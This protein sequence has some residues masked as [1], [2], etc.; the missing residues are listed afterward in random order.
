MRTLPLRVPVIPGESLDSWLEALAR[1]NGLT[2]SGL[3]PSLGWQ[4]PHVFSRLVVNVPVPILRGI[5]HR[6]GLP[7]GRL[8]DAVLD[9][10]LPALPVRRTG[11]RYCPSCLAAN[12]GRWLLAWHLPWVFTCT[13]HRILLCDTCPGCGHVPRVL[14]GVAGV[15]P[16]GSCP[17]T[18]AGSASR[19]C[20][21]DLRADPRRHAPR[22]QMLA[23]QHWINTILGIDGTAT[24]VSAQQLSDLE[25]VAHWAL[26]RCSASDFASFGRHVHQ[27][28][29]Q[30]SPGPDGRL[31]L[32][33]PSRPPV[34]SSPAPPPPPRTRFS[35]VTMRWPSPGSAPWR[36]SGAERRSRSDRAAWPPSGGPSY[37]ARPGPGFCAPPTPACHPSS[38]YGTAA[39]RRWPACPATAL[40]RWRHGLGTFPRRYGLDGPSG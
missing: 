35:P 30:T 14:Y 13:Q 15:N 40:R 9:R 21:T 18:Q 27:A 11:S 4:A 12:G 29:Q 20:A 1:R 6:A 32:A 2:I 8:D 33:S 31:S 5:E 23:A 24:P 17:V 25:I 28:W 26:R 39:A 37:P 3:L 16:A 7:P 10:Y 36:G 38:G 34:P 22:G 19:Y